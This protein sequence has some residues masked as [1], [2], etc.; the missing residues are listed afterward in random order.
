VYEKYAK[1]CTRAYQINLCIRQLV[2]EKTGKE[3]L[4]T[5]IVSILV[6]SLQAKS[7]KSLWIKYKRLVKR[8]PLDKALLKEVSEFFTMELDDGKTTKQFEF[9]F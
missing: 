8:T 1:V 2:L 7:R 9:G 5:E 6:D 3:L 4:L